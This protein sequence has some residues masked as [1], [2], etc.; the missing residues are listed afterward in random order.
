M[1]AERDGVASG[2]FHVGERQ[3]QAR[4]GVRE[5]MDQRGARAIRDSMP[6]QNRA[7]FGLLPFLP[8]A[9][10]A[11]G[12]P[13]ATILTGSPGFISSP[14]P[15][16]LRVAALPDR[17][18][19]AAQYFAAGAAIG[20]LG[21]DL[22]TRR[23]NRANGRIARI[24][25]GGFEV[26]IEQSFGNCAQYIQAREIEMMAPP[27]EPAAA[28]R[29]RLSGLD[30]AA[31]EQIARAD[32]FF[33]ASGSDAGM[34]ISHRGGRPGFVRV[35]GGVLTVPDFAGNHYFNTLGNFAAG[36]RAAL[37]FPDFA[38]GTLLNVAGEVEIVW[39]EAEVR[40]FRGAERLWRVRVSSGWRRRGALPIR[41]RLREYA[42]TTMATGTWEA[43][44]TPVSADGQA[45]FSA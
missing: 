6:E 14:D 35:D 16:T 8:V 32:T 20:M 31:R 21:I 44:G 33:V 25:A 17:A 3:V 24:D 22:A 41:W 26:A 10:E 18:D 13:A 29:E 43:T 23:R 9:I 27:N 12:W 36:G 45:A 34:D 28:T 19:P 37:L 15:R 11:G 42:P 4:A 38:N 5:R 30:G 39:D 40:R 2:P 1:E 7:F